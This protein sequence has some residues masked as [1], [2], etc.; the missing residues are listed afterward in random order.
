MELL[1]KA[2]F[3]EIL[4]QYYLDHFGKRNTD[5][6]YEPPAVN[7]RVFARNGKLITLK[8]HV[9]TGEVTVQSEE[10]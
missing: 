5:T 1:T 2:Q 9:L 3:A 8:S 7:V 4:H 10:M 6:W